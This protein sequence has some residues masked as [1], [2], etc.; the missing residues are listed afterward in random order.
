MWLLKY[1]TNTLKQSIQIDKMVYAQLWRE[2]VPNDGVRK[3]QQQRGHNDNNNLLIK[4]STKLI[5]LPPLGS[6]SLRDERYQ[7][8]SSH[9]IVADDE[10]LPLIAQ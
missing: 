6:S 8:M 5:L 9:A 1:L 2:C 3:C 7:A 10:F 4:M